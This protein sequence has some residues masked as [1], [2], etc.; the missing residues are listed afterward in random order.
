MSWSRREILILLLVIIVSI[1]GVI[2]SL[3]FSPFFT[4]SSNDATWQPTLYLANATIDS[5]TQIT[6]YVV[7]FGKTYNVTSVYVDGVI[8]SMMPVY[9]VLDPNQYQ[10][11]VLIGSN[12]NWADGL[13]HNITFVASNG[14]STTIVSISSGHPYQ[15]ID[16]PPFS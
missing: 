2:V 1:S 6:A 14:Y 3:T 8:Q 7:G 16:L 5:S 12:T 10:G 9:A 11:F 4:G 13:S 15:Q